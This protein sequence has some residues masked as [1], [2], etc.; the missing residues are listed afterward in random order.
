M[1]IFSQSASWSLAPKTL[2][3]QLAA[4]QDAP[5]LH[6][7]AGNPAPGQERQ[8]EERIRQPCTV[9]GC[10]LLADAPG[11]GQGS[12]RGRGGGARPVRPLIGGATSS[13]PTTMR[14][15]GRRSSSTSPS[16]RRGK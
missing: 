1:K 3:L 16:R 14:P 7:P 13:A 10:A 5:P 11:Q 15:T 9:G 8:R 6:V 12:R 2:L 4:V